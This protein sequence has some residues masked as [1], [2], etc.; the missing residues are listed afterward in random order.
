MRLAAR[1]RRR[2]RARGEVSLELVPP[3]SAHGNPELEAASA[4]EKALVV[5]LVAR[6]APPKR[7]VVCAYVLEGRPMREVAA[8]LGIPLQ[9]AYAR[10]YSARRELARGWEA[11]SSNAD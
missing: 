2:A 3:P 8:S 6:L 1:H 5:E 4:R 7:E 11:Q 9:T 10:L